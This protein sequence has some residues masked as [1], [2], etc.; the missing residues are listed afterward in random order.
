MLGAPMGGAPMGGA[1]M[2]LRPHRTGGESGLEIRN[3][4]TFHRY[5][6]YLFQLRSDSGSFELR[7]FF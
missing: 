7:V 2:E 4:Q 6:G 3:V 1:P 5:Q